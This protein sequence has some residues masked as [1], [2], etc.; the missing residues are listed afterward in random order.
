VRLNW[1]EAIAS[2]LGWQRRPGANELDELLEEVLGGVVREKGLDDQGRF[3]VVIEAAPGRETLPDLQANGPISWDRT[4]VSRRFRTWFWSNR[5][6]AKI[7]EQ[8][9]LTA[10]EDYRLGRR[11]PVMRM[12]ARLQRALELQ[13]RE[14]VVLAIVGALLAGAFF[15]LISS[16]AGWSAAGLFFLLGTLRAG[17][18]SRELRRRESDER[19]ASFPC[20]A[21]E[22]EA[23][24]LMSAAAEQVTHGTQGD[25][26]QGRCPARRGVSHQLMRT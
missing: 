22:P 12:E 21:R 14:S 4:G 9:A 24:E 5:C 16:L 2:K 11:D 7:Q 15:A 25:P 10:D 1:L 19:L 23:P 20:P 26:G 6:D 18:I 3:V 13:W 17:F 8:L